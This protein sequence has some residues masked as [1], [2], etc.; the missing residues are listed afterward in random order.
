MKK[1]DIRKSFVVVLVIF[2]LIGVLFLAGCNK[3]EADNSDM[4]KITLDSAMTNNG[5]CIKRGSDYYSLMEYISSD[6]SEQYN[7]GSFEHYKDGNVPVYWFATGEVV[8]ESGDFD[9]ITVKAGEKIMDYG[10]GIV[11]CPVEFVG[12]S[13]KAY[14]SETAGF[15]GYWDDEELITF[16]DYDIDFTFYD[17]NGSTVDTFVKGEQ[18]TMEWDDEN[19]HHGTNLVADYRC[20]KRLSGQDIAITPDKKE[21]YLEY[22]TTSL[23]P[24]TYYLMPNS[25]RGGGAVITIE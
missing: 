2:A 22:D 4:F 17:S 21:G 11:F 19:G 5:A 15:A 3:K 10:E 1:L 8:I 13:P 23:L 12:Y 6:K 9:P 20:Y 7:S 18:Y 16:S 14:I 25:W 24:G